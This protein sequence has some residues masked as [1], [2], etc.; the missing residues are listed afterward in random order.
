MTVTP[1]L[2]V[3]AI[4][5]GT[6]ALG[7]L[8]FR[9]WQQTRPP[10]GVFNLGDI[11]F[12]LGSIVVLPLLYLVMPTWLLVGM[13]ALGALSAIY[14]AAE[15]ILKSASACWLLIA[16]LGIG[17]GWAGFVADPAGLALVILN[18]G[19]I[20]VAVVGVANLWVQ[21]GIRARDA[22]I[23]GGALCVYDLVATSL[24]PLMSDLMTRVA[25]MP[26]GPV[27]AW[28]DE[29]SG[30]EALIGMGDLLLATMFPLVMRKGYG[31][32]AGQVAFVA[33]CAS[34]VAPSGLDL[35]YPVSIFPVMTVLGPAMVI[36]HLWWS[37]RTGAERT[38][39][40]YLQAEPLG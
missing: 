28:K 10:V 7:S 11:A 38:T 31:R 16:L 9:R 26:F 30:L 22:A 27:V 34:I 15:P 25:T 33:S 3:L 17:E 19:V 36:Q 14:F 1:D 40:Q 13:M 24:L 4:S 5:F 23:L 32:T 29:T 21:S 37:R 6:V 20:V 18:N 39:W 35:I 12:M 2:V 8:Y